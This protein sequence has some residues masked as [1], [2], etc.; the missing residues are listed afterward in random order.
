MTTTSAAIV[1]FSLRTPIGHV[2][3]ESAHGALVGVRLP[4]EPRRPRHDVDDV[5]PVLESAATQLLEY[6]AGERTRF[7]LATE[8]DGTEFQ[9]RVWAELGRIPYGQTVTYGELA[10][11]VGRPGGARA[12]GQANGRNPLPIVVPCHRVVARDGLGGYSGGIDVKRA[13]LA[14]EGVAT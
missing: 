13:L 1:T 12:V 7:D 4:A 9:L 6:F 3:L 14:Q 11:R 8:P 5:P 10:R 2:V